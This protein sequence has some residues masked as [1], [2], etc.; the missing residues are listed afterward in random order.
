MTDEKKFDI[1]K[2][3]FDDVLAAY[4]PN[5][6]KLLS[7]VW[8]ETRQEIIADFPS[9]S[10]PAQEQYDKA[11]FTALDDIK[12]M[13]KIA[14]RAEVAPST[15]Y[16]F[17]DGK[18]KSYKTA[19][20]II[21]VFKALPGNGARDIWEAAFSRGSIHWHE[22]IRAAT[23]NPEATRIARMHVEGH[24]RVEGSIVEI[25]GFGNDVPDGTPQSF[26]IPPDFIHITD[27]GVPF[28]RF[29]ADIIDDETIA[30]L[31]LKEQAGKN[32]NGVKYALVSVEPPDRSEGTRT[33]DLTVE[34]TD[35]FTIQGCL[36]KIR[37]VEN[38]LGDF[39]EDRS[40]ERKLHGRSMPSNNRVPHAFC[41]HYTIRFG[42]GTFLAFHRP[43]KVSYE[44][45]KVSVSGEEQL[46]A[47]DFAEGP[48]RVMARWIERAF[49]EEVIPLRDSEKAKEPEVVSYRKKMI[50]TIAYSRCLSLIYEE[51]YCGFAV[52]C[53]IQLKSDREKYIKDYRDGL[54]M[55]QRPDYEGERFWFDPNSLRRFVETGRLKLQPL[56]PD[57]RNPISATLGAK[58]SPDS[59]EYDLHG[60]S[61]HRLILVGRATRLI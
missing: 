28:E 40:N 56:D 55:A 50:E 9:R 51:R 16:E 5:F 12:S 24:A 15:L 26:G 21:H 30:D 45:L 58:A 44:K 33:L 1:D 8:E 29:D 42:D 48:E 32:P 11:G 47:S 3:E 18:S 19:M 22:S 57:Q 61:L 35:H 23:E 14:G 43:R 10:G 2:T 39:L 13:R 31:E 34:K 59:E 53:F 27:F 4:G 38:E 46:A 41:L 6:W 36:A 17:A 54:K 52:T 60:S 20:E 49:L 37:D 25:R 7:K